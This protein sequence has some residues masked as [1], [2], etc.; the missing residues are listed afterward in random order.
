M[1]ITLNCTIVYM[2]LN[3]ANI[4]LC[5]I[6]LYFFLKMPRLV[7]LIHIEKCNYFYSNIVLLESIKLCSQLDLCCIKVQRR[8][9][10]SECAQCVSLC[11]RQT[12]VHRDGSSTATFLL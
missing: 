3:D 5:V 10:M 7:R 1:S 6:V 4:H 2:S 11:E 9:T 8:D 12:Q